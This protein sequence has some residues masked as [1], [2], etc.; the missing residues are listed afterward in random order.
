MKKLACVAGAV[1]A[2]SLAAPVVYADDLDLLPSRYQLSDKEIRN[3]LIFAGTLLLD[4]AQ[5][6]DIK[7]HPGHYE[8]NP[9]LGRH[10]HD[11]R[12]AAY[13]LVAGLGHYA[14]TK[15]LP[16]EWRPAWQYG[17]IALEVFTILRNQ[18][19]GVNFEF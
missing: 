4:Y 5:T 3:E 11:D 19:V 16:P 2:L 14:V 7:N 6:K 9:I 17:W 12:I 13:F 15:A 1:L 18:R 10:P 8:T